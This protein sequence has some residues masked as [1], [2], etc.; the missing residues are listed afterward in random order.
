MLTL[1]LVGLLL[2]EF[3]RIHNYPATT[4]WLETHDHFQVWLLVLAGFT[5]GIFLIYLLFTLPQGAR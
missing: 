5:I 1:C 2:W 3:K 4:S